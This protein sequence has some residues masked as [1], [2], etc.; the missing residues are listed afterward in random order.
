MADGGADSL[1][2]VNCNLQPAQY[3]R[4][5]KMSMRAMT[6]TITVVMVGRRS[7]NIEGDGE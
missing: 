7:S 4:W 1:G 2:D 6:A 5:R 3:E